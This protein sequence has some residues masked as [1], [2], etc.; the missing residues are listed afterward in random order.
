METE[1]LDKVFAYVTQL[2]KEYKCVRFYKDYFKFYRHDGFNK[3]FPCRSASHLVNMRPD[4][5]I[6]FP[7][8]FV[9]LHRGAPNMSLRE[10]YES[11]EVREIIRQS[12][13][14]WDFCKGCKIGCP[15][16]V[17]A[18]RNSPLTS[19]RSAMDFMQLN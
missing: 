12:P 14:M 1:A 9:S 2:K 19:I 17:S 5:S 11:P 8:A 10:I 18:Y 3:K 15:Y 13:E 16:E 6:Q 4:G 7:C